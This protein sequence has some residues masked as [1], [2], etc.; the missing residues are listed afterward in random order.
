[1]NWTKA[2]AYFIVFLMAFSVLGAIGGSF[3]SKDEGRTEYNGFDFINM[4]GQWML[5]LE[6]KDYY[7][8][9][10]PEEL[11]NI[12]SPDADLNVQRIYLAYSP[13]DTINFDKA[14]NSIGYV[15]YHSKGTMLQKACVVEEG[16]PDIPIIDCQEKEGIVIVSGEGNSYTQDKKCLIITATDNQELEK[17]TERLMYSLL[18]VMK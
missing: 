11:E 1:M 5:K 14:F 2:M 18:K 12:T 16:C 15:L 8:Q 9:Y 3:F 17:L 10:L 6:D 7:F 4:G 13:V